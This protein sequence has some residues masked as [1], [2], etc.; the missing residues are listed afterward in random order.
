MNTITHRMDK[1]ERENLTNRNHTM[2]LVKELSS[3]YVWE[4][5]E[6]FGSEDRLHVCVEGG[7]RKGGEM[8]S[9]LILPSCVAFDN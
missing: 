3:P 7:E 2:R 6:R 9:H 8:S 1:V 5:S 4:A